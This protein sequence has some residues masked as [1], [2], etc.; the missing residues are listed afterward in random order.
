VRRIRPRG[1]DGRQRWS[2][3][4][5]SRRVEGA[6]EGRR[7]DRRG[8]WHR[9]LQ[10]AVSQCPVRWHPERRR[11]GRRFAGSRRCVAG[12]GFVRSSTVGSPGS[13]FV[14]WSRST[15]PR[16]SRPALPSSQPGT[17][18]AHLTY[19]RGLCRSD[20]RGAFR[21]VAPIGFPLGKQS[22]WG[23]FRGS[24]PIRRSSYILGFVG[25]AMPR[26][27]MDDT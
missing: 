13:R 11:P 18:T 21:V 26:L 23:L 4:L 1:R 17:P 12:K 10:N 22:A 3:R 14:L 25:C 7:A 9:K 24:P 16:G 2:R 6:R 19:T 27:E 5:L 8:A 20:R 15:E